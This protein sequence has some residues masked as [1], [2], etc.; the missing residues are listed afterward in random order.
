MGYKGRVL[1]LECREGE[2]WNFAYVLPQLAGQPVGLVVPTSL[3]MG[4]VELPPYF[5]AA[6]E[7]TQDIAMDYLE[8]GIGTRPQHKFEQYATGSSDYNELPAIS[9]GDSNLRYMLEVYVNDFISRVIPMS[10]EQLQH[11]ANASEAAPC[12][13]QPFFFAKWDIFADTWDCQYTIGFPVRIFT[14]LGLSHQKLCP[15]FHISCH[16]LMPD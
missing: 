1:A 6:M 8:T 12:P 13:L 2:E 11:I 9:Q 15:I 7:T 14:Y 16:L 3:Q 10:Q 5:C 4:W